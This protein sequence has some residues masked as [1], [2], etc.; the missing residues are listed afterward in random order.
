MIC[1][2]SCF[3][4]C[5][6]VLS[7]SAIIIGMSFSI[8]ICAFEMSSAVLCV[9]IIHVAFFT[10]FSFSFCRVKITGHLLYCK[11][12]CFWWCRRLSSKSLCLLF[13]TQNHCIGF[14]QVRKGIHAYY[15]ASSLC[16]AFIKPHQELH[17][18][19][20]LHENLNRSSCLTIARGERTEGIL[21]IPQAFEFREKGRD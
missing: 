13:M 5:S 20:C 1:F 3:S 17:G 14:I 16:L 4:T 9:V 10:K 12:R 11:S 7:S 2:R 6:S 15:I 18:L 19:L 21:L 8:A